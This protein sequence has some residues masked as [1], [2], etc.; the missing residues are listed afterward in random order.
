MT[1]EQVRDALDA[2]TTDQL[3]AELIKRPTWQ[4]VVVGG[5]HKK[6]WKGRRQFVFRYSYETLDRDKAVGVL[7]VAAEKLRFKSP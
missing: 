6:D 7:N 3:I 5:E 2:A 1:P 4:G